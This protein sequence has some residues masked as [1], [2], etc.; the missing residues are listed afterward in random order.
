[1]LA[2]GRS[3]KE[4]N[5]INRR[6]WCEQRKL[7]K[8]RLVDGAI[9]E[10]AIEFMSEEAAAGVSF[11]AQRSV[12]RALEDAER[13][14]RRFLAQQARKGGKARK[15]DELQLLIERIVQSQPS[16]TAPQLEA[17][18]IEHQHIEPVQDIDKKVIWFSTRDGRSEQARLTGL[19]DRLFRAKQ[20]LRAR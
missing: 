1:M 11:H 5:Q 18:L 16:I 20:K 6:F 13:I 10:T 8:I 3:L 15:T 17:K 19:K 9:R 7:L 14:G 12:Y 2:S 4:I